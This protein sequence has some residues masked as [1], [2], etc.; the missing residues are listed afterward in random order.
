MCAD[1]TAAACETQQ[2]PRVGP[3]S[4]VRACA[5]AAWE[6]GSGCTAAYAVDGRFL[7]F[8]SEPARAR[9]ARQR[10][11]RRRGG[12]PA[13]ARVHGTLA[14]ARSRLPSGRRRRK[15]RAESAGR[16]RRCGCAGRAAKHAPPAPG[17][18][19][20]ARRCIPRFRVSRIAAPPAAAAGARGALTL[21]EAVLELARHLLQVAAA[22]R[23]GGLAAD[24]L[25]PPVVCAAAARASQRAAGARARAARKGHAQE[26]RRAA[27]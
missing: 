12:G 22:P 8:A 4:G 6:L 25:L 24:G 27:G 5:R 9:R 3:A 21:A 17:G 10:C 20:A 16:R 2:R 7:L 14:L 1:Q 26:R 11:R 13:S 19:S 23:A 18:G 15:R